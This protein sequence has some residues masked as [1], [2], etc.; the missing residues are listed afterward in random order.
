[1]FLAEVL[2]T[3]SQYLLFTQVITQ[4]IT[5][6]LD[7][8]NQ[9]V[10][11][12]AMSLRRERVKLIKQKVKEVLG[13]DVD[14][15]VTE[16]NT[17]VAVHLNLN[18]LATTDGIDADGVVLTA[19]ELAAMAA[20]SGGEELAPLPSKKDILGAQMEQLNKEYQEDKER[21]DHQ[22]WEDKARV[23]QSLQATLAA[24][25]QRRARVQKE[26]KEKEEILAAQQAAASAAAS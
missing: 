2:I 20:L 4:T 11:D 10:K 1:M 18:D 5:K 17:D 25:R 12:S 16:V 9:K 19:E 13:K 23:G 6:D 21:I 24:R 3:S 22:L 26:T 14:I 15:A 7:D 8:I